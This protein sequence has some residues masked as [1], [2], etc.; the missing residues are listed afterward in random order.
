M[1]I[2]AGNIVHVG[3]ETVVIDRI[4][5]AGPG[6]LNIPTEKI[7][8]LGNYQS[9]ATIRDVPDLTFTMDSFDMS[10]EIEAMLTNSYVGRTVTDGV[11]ASSVVLTS[12]TA[13]FT[14]EDVGRMVIVE[15]AGGGS[16][17]QLVTT[18]AVYNSAT[19]V[20]MA[21]AA[22]TTDTALTVRIVENGIDLAT[23][24]PIDI[25][26]QFKPGISDSTPYDVISSVALPFLYMESMS[27]RFGLRDNAQQS[28]SLKG[29]SI[30][31]N[32]GATFVEETVGSGTGGQAVA[33]TYDAYE[34]T[35]D[36]GSRRVLSVTVGSK[37]L[38]QNTDYTEAYGAITNGAAISTVTITD[39]V[40]A[41]DTIRIIYS[42]PQAKQYL[43]AVHADTTVKP[44]AVR[45]KDIYVYVGG[46]DPND[47]ATSAANK[48]GSVQ[49]VNMDWRA[50]LEKDEEFGNYYAVG[51]DFDVPEVNGSCDIKPQDPDELLV[52]IREASGV[53]D[54]YAVLGAQSS[55]PLELDIVV[56]DPDT[57]NTV[58]R[59]HCPDARFTLPGY[60]GRIQTKLTVTMNFESDSG[61]LQ[62]F[63]A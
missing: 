53:S 62:V 15:G 7:Y 10:T 58:K 49:S 47:E 51:Q 17:N 29:D 45:G 3:N 38:V 18:I 34:Y 61:V 11:T 43:Q 27:Y 24:V 22:A 13:A 41:T 37:R 9:V 1:A 14:A 60:S 59:F 6:N 52:K 48:W 2:K 12:A 35:G 8:E 63:E 50:T 19:S 31:Y 30:F 16:N 5:T 56:K 21:D 25:A 39:A 26:S 33:T 57:S 36:G 44:A 46:Y 23:C 54:P 55:T 40:A 42:S 28:V 4:Q 32:P 20:D